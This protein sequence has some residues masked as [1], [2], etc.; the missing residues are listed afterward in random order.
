MASF[1]FALVAL[2]VSLVHAGG[3]LG[4]NG[5]AIT[6]SRYSIDSYQGVVSSGSR[7]VGLG[8]AYVAVAEDVDGNL[9][10]P[11]TPAVRPAY[12]VDYFDYWLGFAISSPTDIQNLDFF[13]SGSTTA[14]RAGGE[15]FV[16]A[17]PALNLQ[18]GTFGIG[19]TAEFQNYGFATPTDAANS[20]Q[21]AMVLAG[22][23]LQAANAFLEHQLVIG[24]GMRILT[25]VVESRTEEASE[26]LFASQ[27]TGSEL[28]VLYRP[29]G[30]P[31]RLGFAWRQAIE[32]TARYQQALLPDASGDIT[33]PGATGPIYLPEGVSIPWDVNL[34]AALQLG[35]AFNPRWR[36]AEG[37]AERA[38]IHYRLRQ[39]DRDAER[40]RRLAAA[41]TEAEQEAVE[42]EL[43]EQQEH[44]D[45]LLEAAIDNARKLIRV[46][47]ATHAGR[48]LMVSAA[49]VISGT[50]EE[51]VGVDSL[52]T[53]EVNRSGKEVV[54]S[55]R[56]GAESEVWPNLLKLRA[57]TY[58]EPT[59][60]ETS[61]P[62][63]HGTFGFDVRLINWDVFGIWSDD[64]LWRLGV[65]G[66]VSQRYSV[67]ALSIGGWY[68][69]WAPSPF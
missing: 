12:S 28:G 52:L 7:S 24:F 8:G 30:L 33:I 41:K 69:R 27:G 49:M 53:Q 45:E 13:N 47:N 35:R 62:R 26:D 37:E 50:A 67:W 31:L 18:W 63:W 16:F 65:S 32:T 25:Q 46:S 2:W 34:G 29:R 64:Y 5:E 42:D 19:L 22:V 43:D 3:P 36:Y 17:T 55:P 54:Y 4:Q 6:T 57:G 23:H 39:L 51:A 10:N 44:D 15:S 9:Q 56:F 40:T 59:R 60:F 68:P 58:L 61:S 11:A 66:D 20:A 14:V 38:A 1:G 21:L 48:Y